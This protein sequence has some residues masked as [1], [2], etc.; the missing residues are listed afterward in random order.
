MKLTTFT[1]ANGLRLGRVQGDQIID[2]AE[3]TG[4][5]LPADILTFLQQGEEAME[6]AREAVPGGIGTLAL[7]DVTLLAPVPAPSKVVA[8]GLNYMDHCRE[9]GREPP[10]TPVTETLAPEAATNSA[11]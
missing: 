2:L 11:G 7:S 3:A 9:S 6:L 10:A 1:G 4:G 5:R 8:I